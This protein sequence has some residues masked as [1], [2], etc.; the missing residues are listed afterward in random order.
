MTGQHLNPEV[1]DEV[2]PTCTCQTP[3]NCQKNFGCDNWEV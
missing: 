3:Y 2:C 1:L